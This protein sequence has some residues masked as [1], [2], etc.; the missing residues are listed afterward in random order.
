MSSFR[1]HVKTDHNGDVEHIRAARKDL[2]ELREKRGDDLSPD[3]LAKFIDQHL[4]GMEGHKSLMAQDADG[5][6]D[7][8]RPQGHLVAPLTAN[9]PYLDRPAGT[10]K[11]AGDDDDLSKLVPDGIRAVI[12]AAPVAARVYGTDGLTMVPRAGQ[13]PIS[14]GRA[15]V[16]LEFQKFVSVEDED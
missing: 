15:N 12:P 5:L 16:P 3:D 14:A 4:S 10:G 13:P 9:Q 1:H 8:I 6:Y 2:R 11:A 7:E